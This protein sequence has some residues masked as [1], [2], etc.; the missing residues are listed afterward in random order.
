M[1][2]SKIKLLLFL[3]LIP[4][5]LFSQN[6][7]NRIVYLDSLERVA[8]EDKYDFLRIFK[9]YYTEN[10][11]CE[12]YDYYK[13]GKLKMAGTLKDKYALIKHGT[14]V[15]YYENGKK[16]SI[17]NYE[18]NVPFG[19]FYSWY[20]RGDKEVVG[21]FLKIKDPKK[22]FMKVHQYWSRIGIQRV[23]D[24][25]GKFLDDDLSSTSE[26]ELN[27][28]FKDGEWYGKDYV[29]NTTFTEKYKLGKLISGVSIDSTE[30]Q[31]PYTE[32]YI[33]AMPKRGEKHF[34]KYLYNNITVP[35]EAD[36][37]RPRGG[38]VLE[39]EVDKNGWIGNV[40]I[41]EGLGYGLD[42]QAIQILKKYD[43]WK[44]AEKRG[45]KQASTFTI[46]ISIYSK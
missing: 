1:D 22:P 25:K 18:D 41:I 19:K 30:A 34:Y 44:P 7:K 33:E 45:I 42:E 11:Q 5:W 40:K 36:V 26:G 39:F 37:N 23:I 2:H 38:I 4:C 43:Q 32:I 21:E 24:G 29:S 9:N 20:E 27:Q 6:I 17:L 10:Q 31:Y 12:V 13:S 8:N 28:G 35:F 3:F 16:K 46:P 15:Y 14:Y